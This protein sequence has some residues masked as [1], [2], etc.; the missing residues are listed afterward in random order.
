[1]EELPDDKVERD[2]EHAVETL[3]EEEAVDG[4]G[5]D[6]RALS[7]ALETEEVEALVIETVEDD[8]DADDDEQTDDSCR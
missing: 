4:V 1:M 3:E 2:G 7:A 8:G 5:H 6:V